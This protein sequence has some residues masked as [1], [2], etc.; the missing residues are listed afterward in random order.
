MPKRNPDYGNPDHGGR[1]NGDP[2]NRGSDGVN[3]RSKD[4]FIAR[5]AGPCA[6]CGV[7]TP[8]VALVLPPSHETLTLAGDGADGPRPDSWDQVPWSAFLFYVGYLPDGVQLRVQA[9]SKTYRPAVSPAAQGSYWANHCEHCGSLQEDHD[10]FC[11][12]EG[13]FLPVD[14]ASASA[15]ELTRIDEPFA[16]AAAGYA[17]EPEYL[18][19]MI[20][21]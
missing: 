16:A 5:T 9:S 13:A 19:H 8:L 2:A 11:E 20:Q 3:V 17:C 21:T 6:Y 14:A 10:L 7:R 18:E 15:I 1:E 12:P 4:Y